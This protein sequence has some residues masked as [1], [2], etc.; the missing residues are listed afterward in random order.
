LVACA[1]PLI[2]AAVERALGGGDA[3]IADVHSAFGPA[4]SF[5]DFRW[6]DRPQNVQTASRATLREVPHARDHQLP[7]GAADHL[8]HAL[9]TQADRF[10]NLP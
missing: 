5:L 2:R 9:V 7:A 8:L 10:R 4:T 6:A 1:S 3:P